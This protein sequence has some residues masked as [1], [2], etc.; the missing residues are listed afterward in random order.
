MALTIKL[1]Y[2]GLI[3][4]PIFLDSSSNNSH[5]YRL[6]PRLRTILATNHRS[7]SKL[8][9]NILWELCTVLILKFLLLIIHLCVVR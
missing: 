1:R 4:L 8:P 6:G 9:N 2:F 5:F 7:F 3:R